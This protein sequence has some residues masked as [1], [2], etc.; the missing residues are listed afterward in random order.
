VE[1][2]GTLTSQLTADTVL[3]QG[4]TLLMLGSAEQRQR[5][6]EAFD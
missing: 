6:E 4:G 3:P 1:A 5:F 2:Q